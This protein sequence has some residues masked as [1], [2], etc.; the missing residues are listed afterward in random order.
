LIGI[1]TGLGAF[2]KEKIHDLVGN[3]VAYL[4]RMAFRNGFTRKQIVFSSQD[5]ISSGT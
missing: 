3:P 1:D 2:P 5:L 4:V